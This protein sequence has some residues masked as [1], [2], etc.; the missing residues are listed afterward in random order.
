MENWLATCSDCQY[1]D[2][3]FTVCHN[4]CW[5]LVVSAEINAAG[6]PS[7]DS[8]YLNP[9]DGDATLFY[10]VLEANDI[11][12][13]GTLVRK[14]TVSKTSCT[15]EED[16]YC[17]FE[18]D[19]DWVRYAV[20]AKIDGNTTACHPTSAPIYISDSSENTK[21]GFTLWSVSGGYICGFGG[22]NGATTDSCSCGPNV[23]PPAMEGCYRDENDPTSATCWRTDSVIA[24]ARTTPGTITVGMD[25]YE[26]D[27]L[28]GGYS[29]S[30]TWDE[31]DEYGSNELTFKVAGCWPSIDAGWSYTWKAPCAD[32]CSVD[33]CDTPCPFSCDSSG[34]LTYSGDGCTPAVGVVTFTDTSDCPDYHENT[35]LIADLGETTNSL[36]LSCYDDLTSTSIESVVSDLIV[37][38]EADAMV[39][40]EGNPPRPRTYA[41]TLIKEC[42]SCACKSVSITKTVVL[43]PK[44]DGCQVTVTQD[45]VELFTGAKLESATDISIPGRSMGWSFSRSYSSQ[46]T[47]RTELGYGWESNWGR[48]LFMN[49]ADGDLLIDLLDSDDETPDS[50]A[51]VHSFTDADG[52]LVDDTYDPIPTHASI[53]QL[54]WHNRNRPTWQGR[55]TNE[56]DYITVHPV[57]WDRMPSTV[58]EDKTIHVYSGSGTGIPYYYESASSYL[59]PQGEFNNLSVEWSGST[60]STITL[61]YASGGKDVYLGF[62]NPPL[63]TDGRLYKTEDAYGHAITLGYDAMGRIST[64]TDTL[65]RTITLTYYDDPGLARSEKGALLKQI[66]DFTGRKVTYDYDTDGNLTSVDVFGRETRY[67]YMANDDYPDEPRLHHNLNAVYRPREVAD[68]PD[69]PEPVKVILYGTSGEHLDRVVGEFVGALDSGTTITGGFQEFE[70][71]GP[72]DS[73]FDSSVTQDIEN[74]R[75]VAMHR[76]INEAGDTVDTY[77]NIFG[78]TVAT[79]RHGDTGEH[80]VSKQTFDLEGRGMT[81]ESPSGMTGGSDFLDLDSSIDSRLARFL[82]DK[83]TSSSQA[84]CSSCGGAATEHTTNH[85]YGPLG[86]VMSRT[87]HSGNTTTYYFD[88]QESTSETDVLTALANRLGLDGSSS[89]DRSKV[90][91]LIDELDIDLGLGDLNGDGVTNQYFGHV[92][93]VDRPSVTIAA[94]SNQYSINGATQE[95]VSITAYNDHGDVVY[96]IDEEGTKSTYTYDSNGRLIQSNA[97]VS[98]TSFTSANGESMEYTV[99]PANRSNGLNPTAINAKSTYTYDTLGRLATQTDPRGVRTDYTYNDHGEVTCVTRAAAVDTNYG[100]TPA[101]PSYADAPGLEAFAYRTRSFYDANGQVIKTEVEDRAQATGCGAFIETCVEYDILGRVTMTAQELGG[102]TASQVTRYYHDPAGRVVL[103]VHPAGN[104]DFVEYDEMGRQY[105]VTRGVGQLTQ[106]QIDTMVNPPTNTDFNVR[107]GSASTVTYYYDAKGRAYATADA[108]GRITRSVFDSLGRRTRQIAPNGAETVWTYD[109]DGRVTDVK[110]YGQVDADSSSTNTLL[111]HTNT[112]YDDVGRR[113]QTNRWIDLPTGV[114]GDLQRS[115]TLDEGDL[116]GNKPA[117]G[118]WLASRVEYDR[119]GRVTYRVAD[120]N[121]DSETRYDGLGRVAKS[122]DARGNSSQSWYDDAGNVIETKRVDVATTETYDQNS[123][124]DAEFTTTMFYDSLGRMVT[125]IDNMGQATDVRYDSLGRV[126]A[127]AD[128]NGPI[129]DARTFQRRGETSD[130]VSTNNYGNVVLTTYDALGRKTKEEVLLTPMS[131]G[132][133]ACIGR[134]TQG[135]AATLP[136]LDA[137]QG[138]GDGIITT[139]YEY[140]PNGMMSALIDDNGN[141]SVWTFDNQNRKVAEAKGYYV[142]P[143]LAD[144]KDAATT[145]SWSYNADTSVSVQTKED[146]TVLAYTYDTHGRLTQIDVTATSGVIGT[147][148]QRF[149][150]DGLGRRMAS[151]DNNDPSTTNDDAVATWRYDSLGRQVE[152]TL[153]IGAN[154]TTQTVTTNYKGARKSSLVYPNGR[155]IHYSYHGGGPLE[156]ISDTADHANPIVTYEYIGGRT[157][158]KMMQNGILL[159]MRGDLGSF[160]DLGRPS[161]YAW[162]YIYNDADPEDPPEYEVDTKMSFVYGYDRAGNK[163]LQYLWPN[164]NDSQRYAYDSSNRLTSYN[165]G[166]YVGATDPCDDLGATWSDQTVARRWALDGLGNW[167][168]IETTDSSGATSESRLSTTFNEYSKVGSATQ[169]HDANGNLT[170]DGSQHYQWDAFNRL[171]VALDSSLNTL[172]TYTYDAGNRRMRKV[173]TIDAATNTTDFYYTGWQVLEER[174]IAGDNKPTTPY[175]QFVYGN[176]IDEPI[177]M[178]VNENPGADSSTTGSA[179]SRYFYL[180]NTLYSVYALT[181]EDQNIVEAYEYDPYGKH[182]LLTDGDSDGVVEFNATDTRTDMGESGVDNPYA[183]TSRRHDDETVLLYCRN[184]LLD[185]RI[186]RYISVDPL[187]IVAGANVREYLASEPL[188]GVDPLGLSPAWIKQ[189]KDSG[190]GEFVLP[191]RETYCLYVDGV[192]RFKKRGPVTTNLNYQWLRRDGKGVVRLEASSGEAWQRE[193]QADRIERPARGTGIHFV[194]VEGHGVTVKGADVYYDYSVYTLLGGDLSWHA[195]FA[196]FNEHV[197]VKAWTIH[198]TEGEGTMSPISNIVSPF[199]SGIIDNEFTIGKENPKIDKHRKRL[200]PPS[201]FFGSTT[202]KHPVKNL[203]FIPSDGKQMRIDVNPLAKRG[204]GGFNLFGVRVEFP[205][206]PR[207][208]MVNP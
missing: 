141:K 46:E 182:V 122:I 165:R 145:I 135:F 22:E 173:A 126:V 129:S 203:W 5:G 107:G 119:A 157:I 2:C 180:Q 147:T 148:E 100:Q 6:L 79:V 204:G 189:P 118:K 28:K 74:S 26:W 192:L 131:L 133:G 47:K 51:G 208:S 69:D 184:R 38:T 134:D 72:S 49:D 8:Y 137:N 65:G 33:D 188:S 186:G 102:S 4:T 16:A 121:S 55:E 58:D 155:G 142:A 27:D 31:E 158:T 45:S 206:A 114:S 105:K 172:G 94:G 67:G 39:D 124:D 13:L 187:G 163:T 3:D 57:D 89:T 110:Q 36:K 21:K 96:E 62:H 112:V 154:N 32:G 44:M 24:V 15:P 178:D 108:A 48:R 19:G 109:E 30:P 76:H 144:R 61:T 53:P 156:S 200:P 42:G 1:I 29:I 199:G 179:D 116:S 150:Y 95:R 191:D 151:F 88:Y 37:F 12:V 130:N 40:S 193:Y 56:V 17:E 111:S 176:Y 113:I 185:T 14:K 159:D 104:A 92:V 175:R 83:V 43:T 201:R 153:Q 190:L 66:E 125:R 20:R 68:D 11:Y 91:G 195:G 64:F 35:W 87:D 50:W 120:D 143:A 106:N 128:A 25:R 98:Y 139:K 7:S 77:T 86:N 60:P 10:S 171:R 198:K 78:Y 202:A 41:V 138:G 97:D 168:S 196:A 34:T 73:E 18:S 93:R 167:Q 164:A 194:L 115:V 82:E 146:G 205:G 174:E 81:S 152:E 99:N 181:D 80:L 162:G 23:Q 9:D 54:S 169:A 117:T 161:T 63:L 70:T 90:S 84:G 170:F 136:L 52:D 85:T 197:L 127:T 149:L 75:A 160:D 166:T 132:D 123:I 177:T 71:F 183:F 103:T 59:S 207:N 101:E 140:D